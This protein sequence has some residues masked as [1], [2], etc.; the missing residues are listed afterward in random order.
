[1]SQ[2]SSCPYPRLKKKT[3]FA[4]SG[5]SFGPVEWAQTEKK[6]AP[7][8]GWV[9]ENAE[10]PAA[11]ELDGLPQGAGALVWDRIGFPQETFFL[12][13]RE[14]EKGGANDVQ[15]W[16]VPGEPIFGSTR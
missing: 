2:F 3:R 11:A 9:R 8:M 13:Q 6:K 15:P 10:V 14:P 16:Q 1:M 4:D 12:L 5:R 7:M